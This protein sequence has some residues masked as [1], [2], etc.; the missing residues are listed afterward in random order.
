MRRGA[1]IM[2]HLTRGKK[3]QAR[4]SIEH[5]EIVADS[6][7]EAIFHMIMMIMIQHQNG[8]PLADNWLVGIY[9]IFQKAE[10]RGYEL[11]AIDALSVL[12]G[13][14]LTP[15]EI[16]IYLAALDAAGWIKQEDFEEAF[17]NSEEESEKDLSKPKQLGDLIARV[18]PAAKRSCVCSRPKRRA[19]PE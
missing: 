4:R 11:T 15:E 9:R 17:M 14:D 7:I 13:G 6:W 2:K 8:A 3:K 5:P 1:R 16:G 10:A 19:D 12:I 18:L